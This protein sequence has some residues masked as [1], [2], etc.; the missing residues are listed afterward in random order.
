MASKKVSSVKRTVALCYVRQSFTRKIRDAET[1]EQIFPP[2]YHLDMDSPERQ[3]DNIERLCAA[4]GWTVEWYQDTE[5]HKSGTKE[6]NRPGWLALQERLNDADI[7]AVVAND[8]ARLHR[9]GWRIGRLIDMLEERGVYLVLAAPGRELDLSKPQDRIAIQ[10]IAMIDEWYAVDS[11]MRL[12]DS[13]NY[14]HRKGVT[15]GRPPFGTARNDDGYLI[16]SPSGAWFLPLGNHIPGKEGDSIPQEN[17]I[18]RGY[19][20]CA[21]RALTIYSE[22]TL[23]SERIALFMNTEGWAFRGMDGQPHPLNKD[24]IRRIIS[25][26][27]EYAGLVPGG[28]AKDKISARLEDPLSELVETGRNVMDMELLQSV[29]TIQA[30]RSYKKSRLGHKR[31]IHLYSL[32]GILYCAHCAADAREKQ[33]FKL[34]ATITGHKS[35]G[36]TPRYRHKNGHLCRAQ[37]HSVM[38]SEIE[39][40]FIRFIRLL[41]V[42]EQKMVE[43][44]AEL[45]AISH[46]QDLRNPDAPDQEQEKQIAIAKCRKRID[47]ARSLCLAGDMETEE[48]LRIKENNEREIAHWQARTV[49]LEQATLEVA[50]CV[51]TIERLSKLWDMSSGEDRQGMVRMLF[52]YIEYDLDTRRFTDFR[53]K[54][55]ADNFLI[56]RSALYDTENPQLSEGR[57]EKTTS[58]TG[59]KS[60]ATSVPLGGI[61][62]TTF[63]LEGDRSIL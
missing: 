13:V 20:D 15:V 57:K 11:R 14:R 38:R 31:D 42:D 60:E 49:E 29:A 6:H 37:S 24:D 19:Y 16:P 34:N 9:K 45:D 54:S 22:D 33:N 18:W 3:R 27:R 46:R 23:G 36:K 5:G 39:G 21:V 25:N 10:I 30:S 61:E 55:W 35:G 4:K 44:M 8:L 2:Q 40:D 51:E 12:V 28:K 53:L 17:A 50:L 59:T 56:L 62:P 1:P 52:E 32:S 58:E 47:N 43:Y 48:Y 63:R 26:W 7:V 41:T